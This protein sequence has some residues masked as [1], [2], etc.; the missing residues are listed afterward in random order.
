MVYYRVV[1]CTS[2]VRT[3]MVFSA[4]FVAQKSC[5]VAVL[6]TFN[7]LFKAKRFASTQQL[8]ETLNR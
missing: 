7:M 1:P 2:V 6:R 3:S 8:K 5:L 4:V